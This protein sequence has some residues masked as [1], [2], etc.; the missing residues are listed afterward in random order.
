[1]R[2]PKSGGFPAA[3]ATGD[4]DSASP[5]FGGESKACDSSRG[6]RHTPSP[7]RAPSRA[8]FG[9][10]SVRVVAFHHHQPAWPNRRLAIRNAP[11]APIADVGRCGLVA[12][13]RRIAA[14]RSGSL[15]ASSGHAGQQ[16]RYRA[17]RR[18]VNSPPKTTS[19]PPS[20]GFS[21]SPPRC[22]NA[23]DAADRQR[24][25]G[26][27]ENNIRDGVDLAPPPQPVP[28]NPKENIGRVPDRVIDNDLEFKG[29]APAQGRPVQKRSGAVHTANSSSLSAPE[30]G[31]T[32]WT[33]IVTHGEQLFCALAEG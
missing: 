25:L 6:L 30:I 2:K 33:V 14:E 32:F 24:L 26:T 4:K 22:P 3:T 1:M 15:A 28:P 11:A 20:G 31:L 13:P 12:S 17:G 27:P 7:S 23:N 5:A 18:Q 21:F 10:F 19:K 16:G 8:G 9:R 29:E